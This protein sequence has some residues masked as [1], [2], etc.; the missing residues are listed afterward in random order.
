MPEAD[1]KKDLERLHM[2]W[3]QFQI[4]MRKKGASL[5]A[6]GYLRHG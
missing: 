4:T 6:E 2:S 1:L 3:L 5:K